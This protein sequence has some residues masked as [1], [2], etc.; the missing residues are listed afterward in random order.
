M[1]G[2]GD[3]QPQADYQ[4]VAQPAIWGSVTAGSNVTMLTIP[5]FSALRIDYAALTI[6]YRWEDT[7]VASELQYGN[8]DTGDRGPILAISAFSPP[9]FTEFIYQERYFVNTEV[10]FYLPKA[11]TG[12]VVVLDSAT[13]GGSGGLSFCVVFI[14]YSLAQGPPGSF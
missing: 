1:S 6:R 13:V 5:N 12:T 4:W 9:A 2:M 11:T 8:V 3:I 7:M 14:A 10:P